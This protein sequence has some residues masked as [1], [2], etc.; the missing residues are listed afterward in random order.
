MA[1]YQILTGTLFLLGKR[2]KLKSLKSKE[3]VKGIINYIRMGQ[4]VTDKIF[5]S[6]FSNIRNCSRQ[7]I[8]SE[9]HKLSLYMHIKLCTHIS[10][11]ACISHRCIYAY[12]HAYIKGW[13]YGTMLTVFSS[14]LCPHFLSK[15]YMINPIAFGISIFLKYTIQKT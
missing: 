7:T 6:V 14:I 13:K 4:Y 8:N 3:I 10:G 2:Q 5:P 1:Y 11:C 9:R 12:T 15:F